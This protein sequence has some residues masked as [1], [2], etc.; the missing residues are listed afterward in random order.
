[1]YQTQARPQTPSPSYNLP[2]IEAQIIDHES[3]LQTVAAGHDQ[4]IDHLKQLSQLR[5]QQKVETDRSTAAL[6][7]EIA[8]LRSYVW[9]CLVGMLVMS[10]LALAGSVLQTHQINQLE[11][12]LNVRP[13]QSTVKTDK[14]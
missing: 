11:E 5:Q 8:T 1:M 3:R 12:K 14:K 7:S 9:L 10:S 6:K 13:N 4:I 2:S